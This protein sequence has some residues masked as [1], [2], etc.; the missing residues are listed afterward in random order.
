MVRPSG[1]G[2]DHAESG[3]LRRGTGMAATVT[4]GA[5]RTCWSIIC[6]R[7]HPEDVVGAEHHHEVGLL[8]VDEVQRLVDRVR[9]AGVPV[10]PQPLLGGHRRHVV[11]EQGAHPPGHGD[12]PVQAVALV[13]REHAD[14]R[15]AGVDQVG[16]CEVDQPV[17]AAERHRRFGPV[18][19]QRCQPL[20]GAAGQHNAEYSFARHPVTS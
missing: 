14:P 3:R 4:P 18:G 16:Q 11:A 12:V 7:I 10:R 13:L 8:V 9:R 6:L 20:A 19:G 17:Q 1:A 2:L 15:N 5:R